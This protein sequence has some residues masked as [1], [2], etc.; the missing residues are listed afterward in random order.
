MRISTLCLSLVGLFV[1]ACSQSA[2]PAEEQGES[3]NALM[4]GGGTQLWTTNEVRYCWVSPGAFPSYPGLQA[5][6]RDAMAKSWG[7]LGMQFTETACDGQ[8]AMP[9]M[10][11][12]LG[13]G[14]A[15]LTGIG[16][17][18]AIVNGMQLSSGYLDGSTG[19]TTLQFQIAAV[20]EMG[21]ALGFVHEAD[22]PGSNCPYGA[23]STGGG[24]RSL[25]TFDANSIMNY[26]GMYN[27]DLN[28]LLSQGDQLGFGI[29]Y[30]GLS[31]NPAPPPT[32]TGDDDDDSNSGGDTGTDEPPTVGMQL[33]GDG[34]V[35][36]AGSQVFFQAAISDDVGLSNIQATWS[37][38][39]QTV[40]YP[41]VET[42]T[43][44]V[45]QASTTVSTVAPSGPRTVDISATDTAGQVTTVEVTVYVQ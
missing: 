36:A 42:T 9:V 43:P 33:P 14:I 20:H 24:G 25:T 34:Q 26:C 17:Y 8:T 12:Q 19:Q 29:A 28:S 38:D 23:D 16:R 5:A 11:N 1:A 10:F 22:Q 18:G 27:R 39:D 40:V 6:F 32:T 3:N 44:G 2:A 37:T 30:P 13:S 4:Q 41:M 7:A 35:Y 15:G 31:G 45:Y 21:H